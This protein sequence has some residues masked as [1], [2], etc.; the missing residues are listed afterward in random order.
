MPSD[1][2]EL[3]GRLNEEAHNELTYYRYNRNISLSRHYRRGVLS[4]LKWMTRLSEYYMGR[5]SLMRE[6]F[7]SIVQ[8]ELKKVE[9]VADREYAQGVREAVRS[10][11]AKLDIPIDE[12]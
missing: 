9:R 6:E 7:V 10:I 5:E 3:F 12:G 2:L 1:T 4:A 11:F 8:G